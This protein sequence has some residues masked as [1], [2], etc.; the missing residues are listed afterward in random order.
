M[1]RILGIIYGWF[2]SIYGASLTDYLW[3][4]NCDTQTYDNPNLFNSI[5]LVTLSVVL[6][7]VLLYYYVINH[8]RLN[9]ARHWFL[10]LLIA[11]VV[12]FLIAYYWVSVD[13]N[14]GII[15]D[16]LIYTR[17]EQG[18]ILSQLMF[19]ADLGQFGIANALVSALEFIVFSFIF[20]WGSSNCKHS[21]VL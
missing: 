6:S 11:S 13:Y 4:Y 10:F 8:P 21:P 16:C 7:V 14:T 12:S 17:D 9:R 1:D 5:G 20:K 19:S 18:A 2:E 15:P 3:G